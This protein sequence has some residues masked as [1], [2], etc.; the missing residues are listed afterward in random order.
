MEEGGNSFSADATGLFL[1]SVRYLSECA[2]S[3]WKD[4]DE[5]LEATPA[6]L[7]PLKPFVC[8]AAPKY[9]F[10]QP[11]SSLPIASEAAH[12]ALSEWEKL[13]I[14]ARLQP[15][16]EVDEAEFQRRLSRSQQR[17]RPSFI[18]HVRNHAAAEQSLYT[19]RVEEEYARAQ[20][21]R[22]VVYSRSK[23]LRY[24]RL[25]EQFKQRASAWYRIIV[26]HVFLT[27]LVQERKVHEARE[28]FSKL[29]APMIRRHLALKHR[30]A[31][32][33]QL[34]RENLSRIPFPYPHIIESMHGTFF[35]GWPQFLLEQLASKA[36]PMFLRKGTYLMHEGDIGRVMFMITTGTVSI[37]LRKKGVDKR[38][39]KD[40]SIGVFEIKAPCYVGEFA[41]VCKEPRS[42]SIYCETD[43]GYW[44]V[45]PEDYEEVAKHLSP[46][47][48]SKQ[49]EATD[50]RRRQ[51]LK[52]FFPLKVEWLR[53]MPYFA[54]FSDASL[55]KITESVEPIVLHH[56]DFL[57]QKGELDSSTYFIQDGIAVQRDETGV[58]ST[59]TTGSCVGVFECSCGVNERK[60]SSVVS[61]N[62]CDIW[63]LTRETLIDVGMAEPAALL[64]CRSVAKAER[65]LVMKKPRT[66]FCLRYDPYL[67]FTLLPVHISRL[68]ETATPS[69]YL[70]GER[71]V[72]MGQSVTTLVILWSGTVDVMVI[73]GGQQETFRLSFARPAADAPGQSVDPENAD[74]LATFGSH[75]VSRV[76]GAYEYAAS[77]HQYICSVT[78][79]GLT[80]AYLVEKQ[81]L[82]TV[83]PPLL[84]S[85]LR[86]DT[87]A[88]DILARATKLQD[89]SILFANKEFSFAHQYK[90]R[91][92]SEKERTEK[93]QQ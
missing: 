15:R 32:A 57:F 11:F 2:D 80:E 19:Q 33:Q 41:L 88:R 16:A 58:E 89:F 93:K 76:I 12:H 46:E 52:K 13:A 1:T 9:T 38:R 31:E 69:V 34:L 28:T 48:A 6:P 30:R 4:A 22:E 82:D 77:L 73:K 72:L 54:G 17:N 61:V 55:A 47:V 60:C 87:R 75:G 79:F 49:R 74:M 53:K 7:E 64:R 39:T 78:S 86:S 67:S 51:N 44:A 35:S 14:L 21:R 91:R 43:V 84:Q 85:I 24:H 92:D 63:R 27:A 18:Q 70:N 42:A 37:I 20:M 25:I 66:P 26:C 81:K 90:V 5:V 8:P 56:G 71:V 29:M 45:S 3:G 23:N 40:N 62:Y 65:A 68:F 36:K 50:V 83:V 59:I 10:T